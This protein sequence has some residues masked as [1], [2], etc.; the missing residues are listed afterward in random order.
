VHAPLATLMF[1]GI[2]G[3]LVITTPH[4]NSPFE[5]LLGDGSDFGLKFTYAWLTLP[6][7]TPGAILSADSPSCPVQAGWKGCIESAVE[8]DR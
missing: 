2:R 1:A 5:R 6:T 3:I 8:F 7:N 4:D